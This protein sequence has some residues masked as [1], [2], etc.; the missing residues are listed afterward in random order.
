MQVAL[1][2]GSSFA[3]RSA[4]VG[5]VDLGAPARSADVLY[6]GARMLAT[7]LR[8][9]TESGCLNVKDALSKLHYIT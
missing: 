3:S 6:I 4:L 8:F 2:A 1:L 7:G 9:A 5:G